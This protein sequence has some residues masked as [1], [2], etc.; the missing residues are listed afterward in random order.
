MCRR[1]TI[2]TSCCK[3]VASM[4]RSSNN[5]LST[6]KL[7]SRNEIEHFDALFPHVDNCNSDSNSKQSI[8]SRWVKFSVYEIIRCLIKRECAGVTV[9][10]HI[11]RH[12]IRN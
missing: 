4:K 2:E 6:T 8:L 7:I 9:T 10:S 3:F 5:L 12:N 11:I 1:S